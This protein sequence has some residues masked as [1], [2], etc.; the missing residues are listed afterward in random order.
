MRYV[1]LGIL[2]T[3]LCTGIAA[4]AAVPA[5]AT[6]IALEHRWLQAIETGDRA[7]LNKLLAKNFID[8][9]VHGEIRDRQQAL[10]AP[11]APAGAR[12]QLSDIAV[13]SFG[14]TAVVTGL[15]TITGPKA[16]W[17]VEVRFTDIFVKQRHRW[18]AVSAQE[19]L[20]AA[21]HPVNRN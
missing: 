4:R 1:T 11:A 13:R 9:S 7:Y 18:R 12:Q 10:H 6:L 15:N 19:T 17:R 21:P 14:G 16:A 2:S 3:L 5:R 8:V 20:V